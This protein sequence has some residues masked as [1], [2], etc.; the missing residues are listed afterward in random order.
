[1]RRRIVW[2]GVDGRPEL[3][4]GA[5]EVPG[6]EKSA[7]RIRREER[8]LLA[9]L[10][11]GHFYPRFAFHCSTCDVSELT[12]HGRQSGMSAREIELQPDGFQESRRRLLHLALPVQDG[13]W[14]LRRL[15][16]VGVGWHRCAQVRR[17]CG[18]FT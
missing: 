14:G 4:N 18:T 10:L 9:R 8:R 17:A 12:E 3:R 16:I 2:R 13:S 15:R 5:I 1:M 7:P 11:S 6:V